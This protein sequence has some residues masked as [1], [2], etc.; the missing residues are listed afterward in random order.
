MKKLK[1]KSNNNNRMIIEPLSPISKANNSKTIDIKVKITKNNKYH[2]YNK[3]R[4]I[5]C[6]SLPTK[7]FQFMMYL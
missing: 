5:H 3:E 1:T 4:K 6:S 7:D 2:K